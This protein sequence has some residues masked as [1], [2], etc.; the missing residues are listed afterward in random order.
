MGIQQA[1][2]SPA[3]HSTSSGQASSGQEGSGR[4]ELEWWSY[5]IADFGM[6][7]AETYM[8]LAPHDNYMSSLPSRDSLAVCHPGQVRRR[9]TRAGIQKESDYI[10]L[11][12][13][14]GSRSL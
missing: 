3:T 5:S 11:S 13:D 6:R 8:Y 9:W 10:E 2:G 12:L 1:G 4:K 7:I 14:S